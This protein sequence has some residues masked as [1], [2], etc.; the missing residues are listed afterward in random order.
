MVT[1]PVSV[2]RDGPF[3]QTAA[4]GRHRVTGVCRTIRSLHD[5][6]RQAAGRRRARWSH[7]SPII[8]SGMNFCVRVRI[9]ASG[10]LTDPVPDSHLRPHA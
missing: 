9:P 10:G 7:D 6:R 5:R 1:T 8:L 2:R 4:V 3:V